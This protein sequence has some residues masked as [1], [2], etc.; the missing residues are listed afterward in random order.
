MRKGF[1]FILLFSS[2]AVQATDN[3]IKLVVGVTIDRFY[4]E[5]L[6]I[7]RDDLSNGG[8]KRI[9]N[10]GKRVMADYHYL[11]SQTGVDHTTI[12]TGL[13]PAMHGVVAHSWYD[14]LRG[15]RQN[16]VLSGGHFALGQGNGM[17]A[18]SPEKIEALTLGGVM[19]MTNRFSK[20]Y[21][22]AINGEEA[23]LSGGASANMAFWFGEKSGTWVS[24][25]YYADTIP[26]WLNGY[27]SRIESDFFVQHGWRLLVEEQGRTAAM[28]IKN[29]AE[30][31]GRFYYDIAQAQKKS[32]TYR[33]L[34]A[35]PY[36]NTLVTS[37]AEALITNEKMGWDDD[38]DLLAVSYSCLDYMNRDYDVNSPQLHDVVL[39]LD[40][41]IEKLINTLDMRVGRENYV[42]FVTFSEARELLP[43]EL[44][45][46]KQASGYFSI[47][48]AVALLKSY[49]NLI[50]G[51]GEWITDYDVAQ[52]YL[53]RTLIDEKKISLEEMQDKVADFMIEFEGV[54]K[55]VTAHGLTHSGISSGIDGLFQNSFS[56]KRSGDVLFSLQPTW[57]PELK[58][59]EDS[60]LRYSKRHYLPVYWYGAGID[61][62][63]VTRCY[64][65]DILPTL[66]EMIDIPAPYMTDG[67]SILKK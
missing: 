24:S 50:Y 67:E 46:I 55:V 45:K 47:F 53:N 38:V 21:S 52:I 48:K 40:Q 35:T 30:T 60:Y 39:R 59:I 13:L 43:D 57:I 19:K 4:P 61:R 27:N 51:N 29:R 9:M 18:L 63:N 23:V 31:S 66:C 22:I 14:R 28:K 2:I 37:L 1:F 41:D 42:L 44:A 10:Y 11:Y 62:I 25:N 65:T 36:A 56:Q 7:Y 16:N 32:N 3:K 17:D 54:S 49:L 15:K 33:V 12:Y 8:L 58:D 26:A 34:K 64:M 20:V 5:W 6:Q